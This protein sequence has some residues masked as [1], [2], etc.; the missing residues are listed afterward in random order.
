[1]GSLSL[2]HW[3]LV[4]AVV[5]VLFGAGRLP[6]LMGDFAQGIKAFR[7]GIREGDELPPKLP[8]NE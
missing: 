7:A 2:A 4:L 5:T 3:M 1:M 8:S 6:R